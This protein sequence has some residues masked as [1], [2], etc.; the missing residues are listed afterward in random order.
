MIV[1]LAAL[2]LSMRAP[3]PCWERTIQYTDTRT[4][5]NLKFVDRV[6][7]RKQEAD[8]A[9][10]EVMPVRT[11][12]DEVSVPASREAK[13]EVLKLKLSGTEAVREVNTTDPVGYWS[14]Q[15]LCAWAKASQDPKSEFSWK[16]PDPFRLKG[17]VK[18]KGEQRWLI[19]SGVGAQVPGGISD[20]EVSVEFVPALPRL[21]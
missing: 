7:I 3:D 20:A 8:A 5:L 18:R 4:D 19:L 9:E 17:V 15:A 10:V 12:L 6:T 13:P 14:L 2:V 21:D 1:S 11:V 16:A